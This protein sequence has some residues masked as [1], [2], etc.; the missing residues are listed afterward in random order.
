MEQ[1]AKIMKHMVIFADTARND[2]GY[3]SLIFE[4]GQAALL[5]DW[6][7]DFVVKWLQNQPGN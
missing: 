4:V 7:V 1:L 2:Y 3:S 6:V 5:S